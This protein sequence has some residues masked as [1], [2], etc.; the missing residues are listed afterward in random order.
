M[1]VRRKTITIMS[2][3]TDFLIQLK[4]FCSHYRMIE[5]TKEETVKTRLAILSALTFALAGVLSASIAFAQATT[6]VPQVDQDHST[7][8][9]DATAPSKPGMGMMGKGMMMDGKCGTMG[10]SGMMPG[11][12]QMM[13]MMRQMMAMMSA[14]S[15]AMTSHVEGRI[16]ELKAELKITDA[17]SPQWDRFAEA[18]RGVGK[19]MGE[20]HQQMMQSGQSSALP[21]RLARREK[22]LTAHLA[23]VKSLEEALQ[24]LYASLSDEQKKIAD[25]MTIGPMGMM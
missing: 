13:S 14:E 25:K 15:G 11:D 2:I 18:L 3:G 22:M 9:P 10:E 12:M 6:P 17:Q 1:A 16:A 21:E 5:M 7:H 19:T 23:S 8:H 24:P 20:M 4:D